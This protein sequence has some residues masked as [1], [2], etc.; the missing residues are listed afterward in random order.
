LEKTVGADIVERTE[1]VASD[2]RYSSEIFEIGVVG[3]VDTAGNQ[4]LA[5]VFV[6]LLEEWILALDVLVDSG[7]VDYSLSVLALDVLDDISISQTSGQF[8][9]KNPPCKNGNASLVP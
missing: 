1:I 7:V 9:H 8:F 5:V 4:S 3:V 6:V 2:T